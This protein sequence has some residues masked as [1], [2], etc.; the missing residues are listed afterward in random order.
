MIV[1]ILALQGAFIEHKN[2]L[3][4]LNIENVLIKKAEQVKMCD[5]IILPGGESTAMSIIENEND[6]FNEIQIFIENGKIVWGTCAGMILLAN[7][8]KGKIENQKQIGGLHATIQRNYF[9]SQIQSFIE[10]INYPESF[11]KN[12]SFQAIFIRAPIIL[13]IDKQKHI[14]ILCKL[15]NDTIVAIQEQNLLCTSFHPELSNDCSWHEYFI[16]L[17]KNNLNIFNK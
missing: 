2:I 3:D 5:G 7:D 4:K 17:I 13:S 11:Q 12:G 6:I 15:K 16:N 14:D 1:G 8:I 9:G 10:E